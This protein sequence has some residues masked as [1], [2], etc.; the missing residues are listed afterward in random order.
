LCK[1]KGQKPK[2]INMK[3]KKFIISGGGTGGHIFPAVSIANEIKR[4]LPD[5]EI[6]FVGAKGRMEMEKVPAAGFPIEGLWISGINR[7]SKL[8]N[9]AL[10]FKLIS[11]LFKAHKIIKRFKPDAVIGTGG[12]ASGPV[13]YMAQKNGIPTFIQ[14]QNSFPGITNKKL[15]AGVKKIYV[16]YDHLERFFQ[17]DKIVKT[18]NPIREELYDFSI[19]KQEAASHFDLDADKKTILIVGGSLGARPIN[20][21]MAKIASKLTEKGYQLLWQTGKNG[22]ESHKKYNR[23]A[24]KVVAFIQNMKDAYALADII[25]SRAG[26]GSISE[27]SLIGKPVILVPSPYVAEDHQTK[28]AQALAD[29]NAA[30]LIKETDLDKDLF[31]KINELFTNDLLQKEISQ[32]IKQMAMPKATENIVKDILNENK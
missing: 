30:V 18:G 7:S 15:A 26:A 5:A 6:L 2:K 32:N 29:E 31:D 4:I 1:N 3:K 17:A 21:A 13:L 27:L 10:P 16:A 9:L 11:S 8:K 20:E 23:E 19:S 22:Y 25:I 12:F 14:E 24:V 28:N